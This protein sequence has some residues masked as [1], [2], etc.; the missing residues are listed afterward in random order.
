MDDP[1]R[2]GGIE[3]VGDLDREIEEL[4]RR[5]GLAGDA[6][7]EGLA[8][9]Q[10][11]GDE[12]LTVVSVDVVDGADVGMVQGGRGSGFALEALERRLVVELLRG[13]ELQRNESAEARVLR[14]VH[15]SHATAA[16]LLDDAVVGDRLAD[17][18]PTTG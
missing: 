3:G 2:V 10:L 9:Q 13:E 8:F 15:D 1:F 4:G 16:E 18:E 17:H 7:L 11:H 14:L 5:Q 6:V 12:G